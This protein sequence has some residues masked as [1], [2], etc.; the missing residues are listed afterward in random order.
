MS[1]ILKSKYN[2]L[3][4]TADGTA[5]NAVKIHAPKRLATISR[6]VGGEDTRTY[7]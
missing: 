6:L 3:F 7:K 4:D 5:N 1:Q 2:N